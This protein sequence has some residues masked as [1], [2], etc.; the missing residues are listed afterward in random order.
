MLNNKT[1]AIR[2]IE[3]LEG[4]NR[5]LRAEVQRL[6]NLLV[7]R[8][9]PAPA[10][11]LYGDSSPPEPPPAFDNSVQRAIDRR[12]GT[13]EPEMRILLET[14]ARQN[15]HRPPEEVAQEILVGSSI[16]EV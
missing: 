13:D 3:H 15:A 10:Q 1:F 8:P 4:E 5:E 14:Y 2:M 11:A 7:E 12:A 6:T 16:P 9:L